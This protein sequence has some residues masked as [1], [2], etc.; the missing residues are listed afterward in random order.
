MQRQDLAEPTDIEAMQRR[1]ERSR[2]VTWKNLQLSFLISELN[3]PLSST[4]VYLFNIFTLGIL[5]LSN[6]RAALSTP[7]YPIL[8]PISTIST[9]GMGFI[10]LSRTQTR[11]APTPSFFPSTIVCPNTI[12]LLACLNPLVIQYFQLRG[13]GVSTTNS[14]VLESQVTVVSIFTALLP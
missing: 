4:S 14:D 13:V 7:F 2:S 1:P 11:K 3:L 8:I 10:S 5:T 6:L 9:P 12:A